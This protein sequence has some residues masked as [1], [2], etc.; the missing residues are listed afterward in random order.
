MAVTGMVGFEAQSEFVDYGGSGFI[1]GTASISTT[2]ARTGAASL[3]CNPASGVSGVGSTATSGIVDYQ[4]WGMYIASLP[5][6]ARR[7][8]GVASDSSEVRLNSDGSLSFYS[9]GSLQGSSAALST[10][11]WYW[12]GVRT[13]SG[14]SIACLQVDGVTAVTGTITSGTH[15]SALGFS[16]TEASAVDVYFDDL[17]ADNAGFLQPSKVD[18]ALPISDE[19]ITNVTAGAGGTSNLWD[20]VN[21]TPPAGVASASETNTTNIRFP[22]SATCDYVVNCETYTTL[23]VGASDTIIAVQAII[24]HGEDIATGTK[25]ANATGTQNPSISGM[26]GFT[27]GNDGGAHGAETGV[28]VTL[29]SPIDTSGAGITKGDSPKIQIT[30]I[31]QAR[32]GCVDFMGMLV[33]WTPAVVAPRVPRSTPYP[34]LLPR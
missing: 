33:A 23:G 13:A 17:I 25:T 10:N 24:R 19:T 1:S 9:G 14:T 15:G 5:S 30:R 16:G 18:T 12:I 28:W 6:V 32:V 27:F 8:F 20:A 11:T 3:R 29:L 2:R 31:S 26:T 4:H 21:N 22:A 34:Q 7:M